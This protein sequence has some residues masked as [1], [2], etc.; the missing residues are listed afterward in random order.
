MSAT[1]TRL[2]LRLSSF[3][4]TRGWL[5]TVNETKQERKKR[6]KQKNK[7]VWHFLSLVRVKLRKGKE[8]HG[9][10]LRHGDKQSQ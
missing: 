4:D 7:R 5:T 8:K 10:T 6:N 3:Y 2:R 9:R 1:Q